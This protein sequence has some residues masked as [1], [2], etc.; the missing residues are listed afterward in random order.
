MRSRRPFA[1]A[2]PMARRPQ[3]QGTTRFQGDPDNAIRIEAEQRLA[4]LLWPPPVGLEWI[5]GDGNGITTLGVPN[6]RS[7]P[8]WMMR[9]R[10]DSVASRPV[11]L[12]WLQGRAQLCSSAA[13]IWALLID[14][15]RHF[16]PPSYRNPRV[17]LEAVLS[18]LER[19]TQS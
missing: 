6:S 5:D 9:F 1:G 18:V 4:A 2:C 15:S 14:S 13:L 11:L 7:R 3:R 8:E 16:D 19:S 10:V 12:G 17:V